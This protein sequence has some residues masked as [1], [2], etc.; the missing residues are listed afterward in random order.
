LRHREHA[1]SNGPARRQVGYHGPPYCRACKAVMQR[2][3]VEP[4]PGC[5]EASPCPPC[6]RGPDGGLL[7]LRT[8]VLL[9]GGYSSCGREG[10]L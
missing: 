5:T 4:G 9:A 6:A 8:A 3:L 1:R 7:P 2:H 10:R